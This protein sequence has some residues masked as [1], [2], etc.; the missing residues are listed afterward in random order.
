[1]ILPRST[2]TLGWDHPLP[3]SLTPIH[4]PTSVF[5]AVHGANA[6]CDDMDVLNTPTWSTKLRT[7]GWKG[8][9][10]CASVVAPPEAKLYDK[11][12]EAPLNC[13]TRKPT[14]LSPPLAV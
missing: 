3:T 11:M 5:S 6:G 8:F 10:S 2:V 1:M 14:Q 7:V 4:T 13:D 9:T 12:V